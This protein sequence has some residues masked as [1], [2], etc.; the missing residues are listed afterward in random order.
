M[1]PVVPTLPV[2]PKWCRLMS[3]W[4]TTGLGLPPWSCSFLGWCPSTTRKSCLSSTLSMTEVFHLYWVWTNG[5][6][7]RRGRLGTFRFLSPGRSH[8]PRLD[9]IY[10]STAPPRSLL[11]VRR[12][13]GW[14]A[15]TPQWET[16]PPVSRVIDE[17]CVRVAMFCQRI[18]KSQTK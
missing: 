6:P 1:T 13:V 7:P 16:S 9:H 10:V 15:S 12:S 17:R 18:K 2:G 14:T 8:R 3:K 5:L 11:Q 4:L